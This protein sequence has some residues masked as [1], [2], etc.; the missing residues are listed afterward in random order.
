[1]SNYKVEIKNKCNGTWFLLLSKD[2]TVIRFWSFNRLI[3]AIDMA[4]MLQLHVD[5]VSELPLQQY[6]QGA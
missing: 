5:N 6:N 1:M 2:S 4:S 3:E